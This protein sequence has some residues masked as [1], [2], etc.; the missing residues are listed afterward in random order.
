M[1]VGY[2]LSS[3]RKF[4][5]ANIAIVNYSINKQSVTNTERIKLLTSIKNWRLKL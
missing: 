1:T 4:T 3:L 5:F 2:I